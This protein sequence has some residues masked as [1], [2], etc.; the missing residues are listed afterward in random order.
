MRTPIAETK[1]SLQALLDGRDA[2][3]SAPGLKNLTN[4]DT[5]WSLFTQLPDQGAYASEVF[6]FLAKSGSKRLL[7]RALWAFRFI[8]PSKRS[9]ADYDRAVRLALRKD[10]LRL[11]LSINAEATGRHLNAECSTFLL[12]H[13]TSHL[14]WT[15]AAKVWSTS[16]Q[17]L[18]DNGQYLSSSSLME[19]LFTQ[20]GKYQNMPSAINQLASQLLERRPVITHL[21]GTLLALGRELMNLLVRSGKLM[22]L[23][24]PSGLLA[25]LDNYRAL[26]QLNPTVHLNA[27]NTLLRSASRPDKSG[28]ATLIYHHLRSSFPEFK[29]LASLYGSILS[30]HCNEAAPSSALT[31]YLREFSATHGAADTQS[32]LKVLTALAAQGDVDGVN[33]VF[34]ALCKAHPRPTDVAYYTPLLY[35][36]ARLGDVEGCERQFQRLQEWGVAPNSYCWNILTYA[37]TRSPEPQG[38]LGVYRRMQAEGVTPDVYTFGTLMSIFSKVGDTEAVL[39]IMEQAQHFNVAG[40]YEMISGLAH[41]YCLNDQPDAA[42]RLA[43]ATTKANFEGEPVKVWNHILRHYAFRSDSEGV[44]RV[45][46]RMHALGL[47]PDNMTYAALMTALVVIER[48]KDAAHILRRLSLSQGLAATPFHYAIILHGYVLEGNR[49]MANVIYQEMAERFP[50]IGAGPHLAMLHLQSRR[51]L[52]ASDSPQSATEYLAKVLYEITNQD[53]AGKQPQPGLHRRRAVDAV[54]SIYLEF[55]VNVLLAKGRV[56]QADKL[57]QRYESLTKSSYLHLDQKDSESIGLLATRLSVSTNKHDWED[58]EKLWQQIIDRALSTATPFSATEREEASGRVAGTHTAAP[59][60]PAEGISLLD[61]GPDFAASSLFTPQQPFDSPLD[62]PGLKVLFAQRHLLEPAITCY[63]RSLDLRQLHPAAIEL[64][65][66]LESA[67]FTLTSKNWNFYIQML[68]RSDDPEHWILAF[69][70]FEERMMPNTPSWRL[71]RRGKWSPAVLPGA[72]PDEPLT[73]FRRSALEKLNPEQLMPTYLTTIYLATVL[74]KSSDYF[75]TGDRDVTLNVKASAPNTYRF[76]RSLPRYRDRFQGVL[77]RGRKVRGDLPRRPRRLPRP[78]RAGLLGSLSPF[79]HVPVTELAGLDNVVN[80]N[81]PPDERG[82]SPASVRNKRSRAIQQAERYEGQLIRCPMVVDKKRRVESQYQVKRRLEGEESRLLKT[83]DIIKRDAS[84]PQTMSDMWFGYPSSPSHAQ[85][86][87]QA[88]SPPLHGALYDPYESR[89]EE[90]AEIYKR[91]RDRLLERENGDLRKSQAMPPDMDSR[92]PVRRLEHFSG[93]Y[94]GRPEA[95]AHLPERLLRTRKLA[96][97][98]ILRD[99]AGAERPERSPEG[100]KTVGGARQSNEKRQ[101]TSR[102][103]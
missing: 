43:E 33:R 92:P 25:L 64:V 74:K 70:T 6:H 63:M 69:Q 76:I 80:R 12:L 15:S 37:H 66:K 72:A 1:Q 99:G 31:Y 8:A 36:H 24:T 49:D 41:S 21:A 40:S 23:I 62:R 22:S 34:G 73:V 94:H 100:R 16:F 60:E 42:E 26:K 35:V 9:S 84:R 27:I 53:R 59:P 91:L 44:L 39:N 54:P 83:M 56:E 7:K 97:P 20:V 75:A 30:I 77:L 2:L 79:D 10:D 4:F 47:K 58:V 68:T 90:R 78:N 61:A 50:S 32:Y 71:L 95:Y 14:L 101:R 65:P 19:P 89:L 38:A 67:G 81:A 82:D 51:N 17:P 28:L 5:V 86:I 57:L 29:P 85:T 45:Q 96:L 93:R 52:E 18:I 98:P 3:A 87:K 55:A 13:C 46:E 88:A 103:R 48:T 102:A 11:A